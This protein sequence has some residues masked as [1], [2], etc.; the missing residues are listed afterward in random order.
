M[1]CIIKLV[2]ANSYSSGSQIQVL[3]K[4]WCRVTEKMSVCPNT[5]RQSA[6]AGGGSRAFDP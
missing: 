5:G 6:A 4:N 1:M 3:Q 2:L